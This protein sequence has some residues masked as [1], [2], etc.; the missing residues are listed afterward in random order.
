M[1]KPLEKWQRSM[2]PL[3]QRDAGADGWTAVSAKLFPLIAKMPTT[4]VEIEGDA[5][6]GGRARL[7]DE[8]EGVLRA[9]HLLSA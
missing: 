5:N 4:L 8:G 7:T 1:T 3:I 9:A 6:S 2:L